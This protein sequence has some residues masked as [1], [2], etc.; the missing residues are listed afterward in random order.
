MIKQIQMIILCLGFSYTGFVHAE[1]PAWAGNGQPTA[2]Q[3]AM[4]K[5]AMNAKQDDSEDDVEDEMKKDKTKKDK[6]EN[7]TEKNKVGG[8]TNAGLEKQKAKKAAMQQ[9]E[10]DKGS[11]Q[12]QESR[13]DRKKWWKFW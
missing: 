3:K 12:G 11:E 6:D 13:E 7:D 5:E 1:K 4:H 9:K 10:M 2:E 8:K